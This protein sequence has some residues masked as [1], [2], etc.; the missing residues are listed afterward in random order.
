MGHELGSPLPNHFIETKRLSRYVREFSLF[1]F[2]WDD[3]R[4]I[5]ESFLD[6]ILTNIKTP[7]TSKETSMLRSKLCCVITAWLLQ[8]QWTKPGDEV[9]IHICTPNKNKLNGL[10][11][12][13]MKIALM[14]MNTITTCRN[15]FPTEF[16]GNVGSADGLSVQALGRLF[17]FRIMLT[18]RNS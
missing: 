4:N 2:H 15:T 14:E 10:L 6:C 3:V 16:D 12:R 9:P 1:V 11:I 5:L 7:L 18:N 13:S 8:P 17:V